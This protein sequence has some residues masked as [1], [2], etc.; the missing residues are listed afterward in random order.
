MNLKIENLSSTLS[1]AEFYIRQDGNI[2][3]HIDEIPSNA[4]IRFLGYTKFRLLFP[5]EIEMVDLRNS[6]RYI[7][8][9]RS[10]FCVASYKLAGT[11]N[12]LLITFQ[13]KKI[14]Q[15]WLHFSSFLTYEIRDNCDKRIGAVAFKNPFIIGSQHS[16]V[17]DAKGNNVATFDWK[18]FSFWKGYRD[19]DLLIASDDERWV[20]ISIVAAIIKGLYLQQR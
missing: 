13:P 6:N 14:G 2:L 16:E 18:S 3:Y 9:R 19:C 15:K 10:S 5:L 11:D 17:K 12:S 8:K 20:L 7:I 1:P 4:C